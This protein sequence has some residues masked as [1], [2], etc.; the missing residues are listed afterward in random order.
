VHTGA[1]ADKSANALD[2]LAYTSG[3]DIY[4][5]AGMYTPATDSGSRLLAHEVAHV[6][7]QGAGKEPSIA[8]KSARG[9]KIGAPDDILETEADQSADAFMSGTP[10]TDEEQ[11]KRRE[12]GRPAQRFIQRQPAPADKYH[13][14]AQS[15]SK[16]PSA[17]PSRPDPVPGLGPVRTQDVEDLIKAADFQG[18]IDT[19]VGYKYMDYEIDFN[20]LADKKMTFDPQLTASDGTT[21]MPSWDFVSGKAV[22]PKVRIGPSAF[23]SVSYLYSVIMHEYQHVLWQQ[24]LAHQ[25][26][27]NLAHQQGFES[28]DEVEAGAWEILHATETG[29]A[30]L[31]DKIAD[32]W[33]NLNTAFSKLAAQDQASERPL[34]LR[35]FRKAKDIVRGS[36]VTL[37]PPQ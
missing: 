20:L 4:F 13:I 27:S 37:D 28:P 35:A 31:P 19:L 9:V 8:T 5:A 14:V 16:T 26:I 1:E 29:L 33:K 7:Q 12:A 3:R 22:P 2:A 18:A 11:R 24:T 34:V 17:Q 23:S 32:I 15:Q 10:V 36:Q 21:S 25:G 30:R 6:V